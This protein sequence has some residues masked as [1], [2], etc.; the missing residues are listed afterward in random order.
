[1]IVHTECN[2]DSHDKQQSKNNFKY[3][4]FLAS[5]FILPWACGMSGRG[6]ACCLKNR[7]SSLIFYLTVFICCVRNL[8]ALWNL[9]LCGHKSKRHFEFETTIVRYPI[10]FGGFF[11]LNFVSRLIFDEAHFLLRTVLY[12]QNANYC[13]PSHLLT[14][15]YCWW[16]IFFF[17]FFA[18]RGII[19]SVFSS[20]SGNHNFVCRVLSGKMPEKIKLYWE[21]FAKINT[22]KITKCI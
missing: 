17:F 21:L 14:L 22:N 3:L 12:L 2:F 6:R 7:S 11:F 13:L 20:W 18:S 19:L 5:L 4:L 8:Y 1:M 9:W 10:Y 16:F 15:S